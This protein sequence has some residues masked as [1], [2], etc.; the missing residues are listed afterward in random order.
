MPCLKTNGVH[1]VLDYAAVAAVGWVAHAHFPLHCPDSKSENVYPG[2]DNQQ[3]SQSIHH[4]WATGQEALLQWERGENGKKNDWHWG[5]TGAAFLS[6]LTA[7][8]CFRADIFSL[9]IHSEFIYP[10]KKFHTV[11]MC[12]RVCV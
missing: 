2:S 7:N 9:H 3:L 8:H 4:F 6:G 5:T 11:C 1:F 10:W 12:V